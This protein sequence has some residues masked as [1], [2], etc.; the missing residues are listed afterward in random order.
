MKL[1]KQTSLGLIIDIQ[2]R[3]LPA[4]G[5]P[6]SIEEACSTL[7]QGLQAL[8][9]PVLHTEQ[10]PRGLGHTVLPLQSHLNGFNPPS[11]CYEKLSFSCLSDGAIREAIRKTG[12]KQL[13]VAGIETHVCLQQTV[14]EALNLDMEVMVV[15]DAAGSRSI[16]DHHQALERMRQEGARI[17]SVE[18]ILFELLETAEDP[19][20]RT[21]SRLIK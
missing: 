5:N 18:S 9:V 4:M 16:I 8:D 13:I 7:L 17:G 19:A 3:L 2:E 20:F 21:I 12:A 10:Y 14:L 6:D 1:E 15:H 11:P